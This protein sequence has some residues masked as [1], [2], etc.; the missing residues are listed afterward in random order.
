MTFVIQIQFIDRIL[1]KQAVLP[2]IDIL[3]MYA[4]KKA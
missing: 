3:I 2:K 1:K 4:G